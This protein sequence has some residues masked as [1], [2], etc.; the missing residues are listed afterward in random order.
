VVPFDAA[1]HAVRSLA[2][3]YW[4]RARAV[5]IR[6]VDERGRKFT[7]PVPDAV[8]LDD[9]AGDE[10]PLPGTIRMPGCSLAILR[11]LMDSDRPMTAVELGTA[12][13]RHETVA[14]YSRSSIEKCL[15]ELISV[16]LLKNPKG[17]KPK[18]YPPAE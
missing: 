13:Q 12:M 5:Y 17:V 2:E 4:P 1:L 7:V 16:G 8:V 18:G 6:V 11:V 14:P 3:R 9:I 10:G 15:A